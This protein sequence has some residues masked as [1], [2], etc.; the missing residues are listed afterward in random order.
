M[1]RLTVKQQAILSF[2]RVY[3]AR[4]GAAPTVREIGA[5]F[6]IRST[7][8]VVDHLKALEHKGRLKRI[9]T[10]PRGIEVIDNLRIRFSGTVS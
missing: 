5:A 2:I 9:G 10:M 6:G 1:K 4:A 7:N 8:G 3:R